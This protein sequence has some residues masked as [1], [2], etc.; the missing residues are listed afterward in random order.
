[1]TALRNLL[2]YE[3][4]HH[5]HCLIPASSGGNRPSS[6]EIVGFHRA[7]HWILALIDAGIDQREV[8]VTL[9]YFYD[10]LE[11][12]PEQEIRRL[13]AHVADLEAKLKVL[14]RVSQGPFRTADRG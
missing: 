2:H 10:P 6:D 5:D 8:S 9:S 12:T 1:M 13:N 11:N 4:T 7:L 14:T 3:T